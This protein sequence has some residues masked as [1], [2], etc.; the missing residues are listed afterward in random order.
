MVDF[1]NGYGSLTPQNLHF[2]RGGNNKSISGKLTSLE[3]MGVY[4]GRCR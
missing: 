4:V 2:L 3:D 1:Q